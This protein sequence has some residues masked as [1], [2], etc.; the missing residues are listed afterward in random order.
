MPD[1]AMRGRQAVPD[2]ELSLDRILLIYY[3]ELC[4]LPALILVIH[5]QVA[6]AITA[7]GIGEPVTGGTCADEE[8]AC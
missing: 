5:N 3:L 6:I 8:L 7:I 4:P 2:T 1:L